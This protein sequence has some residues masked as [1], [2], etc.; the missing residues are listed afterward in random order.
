MKPF[1][2]NIGYK[3]LLQRLCFERL[4]LQKKIDDVMNKAQS[5]ENETWALGKAKE[6]RRMDDRL[7]S[8]I[9]FNRR[10]LLHYFGTEDQY[11][12]TTFNLTPAATVM[13]ESWAPGREAV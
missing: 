3:G 6:Y 9:A 8:L 5:A 2:P 13:S 10:A 7:R 12:V 4:F 11:K 1:D